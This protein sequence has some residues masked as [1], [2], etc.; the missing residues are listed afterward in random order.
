MVQR[1]RRKIFSLSQLNLGWD[2]LHR[3]SWD[4]STGTKQSNPGVPRNIHNADT[5]PM[6]LFNPLVTLPVED[7]VKR[8]CAFV[9]AETV[10]L[11]PAR[12]CRTA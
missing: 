11:I 12:M 3:F 4:L 10:L 5:I 1:V 9:D 6:R 2:Q 8:Q 7:F